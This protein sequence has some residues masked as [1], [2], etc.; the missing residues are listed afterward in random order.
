MLCPGKPG[1]RWA[2][3][4]G[5]R[6][7]ERASLPA[8]RPVRAR[9][10]GSVSQRGGG[11]K[12]GSRSDHFNCG[13]AA[14]ARTRDSARSRRSARPVP[15]GGGASCG[16]ALV[17]GTPAPGCSPG[18]AVTPA[19]REEAGRL[20]HGALGL[21]GAAHAPPSHR[22]RFFRSCWACAAFLRREETLPSQLC[23]IRLHSRADVSRYGVSPLSSRLECSGVISAYCSLRL[24]D[25]NDSP[26]SASQVAG[27]TDITT[28]PQR[29]TQDSHTMTP[30]SSVSPATFGHGSGSLR[31]SGTL[32]GGTG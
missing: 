3:A 16:G 15:A 1:E 12:A 18:T 13:S 4:L 30:F 6:G 31:K 29:G 25:S 5:T 22:L 8:R 7:M 10:A 21:R 32:N 11:G 17:A 26:A 9:P 24:P 19:L 27:I 23:D 14:G 28:L 2:R 20:G